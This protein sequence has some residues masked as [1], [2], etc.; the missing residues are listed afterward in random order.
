MRRLI[1]VLCDYERRMVLDGIKS[2]VVGN[3]R[4]IMLNEAWELLEEV[5]AG[6]LTVEQLR[7]LFITESELIELEERGRPVKA[8]NN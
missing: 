3:P 1:A 7:E 5:L 6:N 4:L 8:T 2:E